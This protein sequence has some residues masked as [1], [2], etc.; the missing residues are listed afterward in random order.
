MA[1]RALQC[2][3]KSDRVARIARIAGA[4]IVADRVVLEVAAVVVRP[5]DPADGVRQ[6]GVPRGAISAMRGVPPNGGVLCRAC[7][8]RWKFHSYP[9]A[10]S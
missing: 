5:R 2:F 7:T 10:S 6:R 9:S 3:A 1:P 8:C 4:G